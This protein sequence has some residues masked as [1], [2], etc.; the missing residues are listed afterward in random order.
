M[1]TYRRIWVVGQYPSAHVSA[2]AI[3]GESELL[4]SRFTLVAKRHF[5]GMEVTLWLRR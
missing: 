1:I 2:P 5:K 3:R 4:M